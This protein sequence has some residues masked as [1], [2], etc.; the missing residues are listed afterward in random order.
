MLKPKMLT[1]VFL[2]SLSF[3]TAASI[4]IAQE[5]GK[6]SEHT[7]Q[8]NSGMMGNRDGGMMGMM[9]GVDPAQMKRMVENCN[10]MMESMMQNTP[11]SGPEKKG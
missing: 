9:N 10:R 1:T 6:P 4:A 5:S 8:P 2:L 11:T 7:G 3:G